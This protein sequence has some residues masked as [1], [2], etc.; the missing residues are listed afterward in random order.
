MATSHSNSET[1]AVPIVRAHVYELSSVWETINSSVPSLQA[2]HVGVEVYGWEYTVQFIFDEVDP[3]G[4]G[5]VICTPTKASNYIFKESIDLGSTPFSEREA[6]RII[7]RLA[8]DWVS[9]EYHPTRK[10]CVDFS[11]ALVDEL[12]VEREIP[13]WVS[14]AADAS[15]EG[16]VIGW[17]AERGWEGIK[18][19]YGFN[20]RDTIPETPGQDVSKFTVRVQ[21][22]A[23]NSFVT[24]LSDDAKDN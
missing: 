7:N 15:K 16:G 18:W 13:A 2:Y 20:S 5:V 1:R 19:Y 8:Q 21:N 11:R 23:Y 12:K 4:S 10:N 14:S 3:N 17:I 6:K 24:K 9:R 22:R